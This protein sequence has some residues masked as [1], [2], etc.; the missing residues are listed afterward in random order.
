MELELELEL[1]LKGAT[2]QQLARGRDCLIVVIG[3]GVM[4]HVLC[5]LGRADDDELS[6]DERKHTRHS[7]GVSGVRTVVKGRRREVEGE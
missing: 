6:D 3:K 7:R 5:T 1:E 4:I 2:G